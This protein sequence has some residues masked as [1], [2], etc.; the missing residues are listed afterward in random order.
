MVI[1]T[2]VVAASGWERSLF[3]LI[4]LYT[5]NVS[6]LQHYL[7]SASHK[8]L[9]CASK[10]TKKI[11]KNS[12]HI[13]LFKVIAINCN[14]LVGVVFQRMHCSWKISNRNSLQFYRYR[15]LNVAYGCISVPLQFHFQFQKHKI[16]RR[17]QISRVWGWLSLLYEQRAVPV[18]LLSTNAAQIVHSFHF[19]KSSDRMRWTMVFGI[20]YSPYHPIASTV[21][22]LQNSYHLSDVFVH[23]C[24]YRPSALLCIFNRLLTCRKPPM[25]SKYHGTRHGRVTKHFYKHFPHFCNRKSRFTTKFYHGMLFKIF[26]HPNL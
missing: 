8:F 6:R 25:P 11:S 14:T 9:D 2:W 21:V 20:P 18:V 10:T 13:F 17:T 19:F 1:S 16:V 24:C 26:F 22:V 7:H 15:C 23:F 5:I 3:N 4:V 12:K